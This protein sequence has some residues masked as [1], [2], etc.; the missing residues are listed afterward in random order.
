MIRKVGYGE[1]ADGILT[2]GGSL[3]ALT[4]L[5]AMRQAKMP[6]DSWQQG[7]WGVQPGA[8]LVSREAHYCN[9]RACAILGFGER[10]VLPVETDTKYSID[11][12]SLEATHQHS[13]ER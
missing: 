5:L 13:C 6:G 4:A 9:R 10:F 11:L 3:G 1:R 12:G 2:S 7:L 8:V